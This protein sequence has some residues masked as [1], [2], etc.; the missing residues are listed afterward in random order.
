MRYRIGIASSDGK[1]VNQHFGRAQEFH[2]VDADDD[3]NINFVERRAVCPVCNGGNHDDEQLMNSANKL[4]DCNYILV[5][6][7]GQG[8]AAALDSKG[9]SSFEIPGIIEESVSKMLA[10]VEIQNMLYGEKAERK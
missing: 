1:V 5:S 8:A 2:I 3:G 6:K 9:I 4:S 10:Y 7:I